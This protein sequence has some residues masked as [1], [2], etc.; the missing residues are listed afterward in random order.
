MK[1]EV[2]G[3]HRP[4]PLRLVVHHIQPLGMGGPDVASNKVVV[5]DTGHYNIHRLMGY[6]LKGQAL[7]KGLGTRK[8][9]VLANQGYRL[10]ITAGKPGRPVYELWDLTE[11]PT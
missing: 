11:N 10:W 1:C 8:E 2:H 6:L 4:N 3:S 9:R 5:C 7:P